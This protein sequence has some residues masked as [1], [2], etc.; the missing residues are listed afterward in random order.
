MYDLVKNFER[1]KLEKKENIKK[2][3]LIAKYCKDISINEWNKSIKELTSKMASIGYY[4]SETKEI[5]NTKIEDE[6]EFKFLMI[7]EESTILK[8][9]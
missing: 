5:N 4:L 3:I 7:F 9:F 1:L 6:V 8:G 2:V